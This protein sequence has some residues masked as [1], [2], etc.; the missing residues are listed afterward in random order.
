MEKTWIFNKLVDK[1]V[2]Y[3]GLTFPIAVHERLYESIGM[4]LKHGVTVPIEVEVNGRIFEAKL[5]NLNFKKKKFPNRS[6]IVQI[7]YGL[8][9]A[10][11]MHELF[12]TTAATVE[13]YLEK[14]LSGAKR[15]KIENDKREYIRV[16]VVDHS[17]SFSLECLPLG[18]EMNDIFSEETFS[19]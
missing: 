14:R 4:Q 11:Y 10:E 9:L 16:Y 1:S 5:Q 15:L 2:L 8:D 6:D 18:T 12:P 7:R 17:P 3:Q 13:E 19:E